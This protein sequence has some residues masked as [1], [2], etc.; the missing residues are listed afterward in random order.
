MARP[1]QAVVFLGQS[2]QNN[3]VANET[4]R[5]PPDLAQE[6]SGMYWEAWTL[7]RDPWLNK[8]GSLASAYPTPGSGGAAPG[9]KLHSDCRDE[10]GGVGPGLSG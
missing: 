1:T 4:Y 7:G 3:M 8:H 2:E 6:G 9:R 5:G 10:S